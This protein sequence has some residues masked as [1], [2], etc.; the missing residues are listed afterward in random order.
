MLY[1]R[2]SRE[3]ILLRE[4]CESRSQGQPVDLKNS[5]SFID[6]FSSKFKFF[7][8]SHFM[9]RSLSFFYAL[10]YSRR[11]FMRSLSRYLLQTLL[12]RCPV[13]HSPEFKFPR[14]R[15][16]PRQS[17]GVG[18]SRWH[19]RCRQLSQRSRDSRRA[20]HEQ[21]G[22][23]PDAITVARD[24]QIGRRGTQRDSIPQGHSAEFP[25]QKCNDFD[26]VGQSHLQTERLG[27]LSNPRVG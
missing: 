26:P 3:V 18:Y 14:R 8:R 27:S 7:L 6:A 10:I 4:R 25:Q 23:V 20:V 17:G 21:V 5:S 1:D 24:V 19:R 12:D 2:C 16:R 13:E 11:F 9:S 15:D 22:R